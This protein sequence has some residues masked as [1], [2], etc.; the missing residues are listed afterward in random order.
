[1]DQANREDIQFMSPS[2]IRFRA[3]LFHVGN[4][5]CMLAAIGA[6]VAYFL[7]SGLLSTVLSVALIL[8]TILWFGASMAL[9]SFFAEDPH[10]LV[11]RH[12]RRAGY[13]FYGAAGAGLMTIAFLQKVSM[14][15]L[16]P[17][18]ALVVGVIMVMGLRDLWEIWQADLDSEAISLETEVA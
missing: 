16:L 17:I 15:Y 4:L 12:T 9:Y 1:M 7:D 11:A 8:P 6:G 14:A 10:S 5:V 2:R 13:Q 18:P 3:A